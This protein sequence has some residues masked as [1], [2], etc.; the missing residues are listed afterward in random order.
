MKKNF[1]TYATGIAMPS[2]K[3]HQYYLVLFSLCLATIILFGCSVSKNN[4]NTQKVVSTELV[5]RKTILF[6]SPIQNNRIY[7]T[8]TDKTGAALKDVTV[9]FDTQ[10]IALTDESGAFDFNTEKAIGKIYS[11]IFVKQGYNKAVRNYSAHMN[12]AN[13][14]I[15]MVQPCK[16]DSTICNTCSIKNS[17]FDFENN[18][19][20]LTKEQKVALD[21]LIECLKLHPE[22][23]ILIQH[24]TMFP[25]RPIATQRLD[26]VVDYF[27]QKGIMNYRVKK[28]VVSNKNTSAK[29][30]EI[31]DK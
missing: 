14:N 24:N 8:I 1:A 19:Y 16:C 21:A 17:G 29:Q 26:A 7:G 13:Y 2:K 23:E 10:N 6:E 3:Q 31:V 5:K 27:T 15:V 28:E 30:I 25:K 18:S 9:I 11:L 12:D 4:I 22:K 20:T